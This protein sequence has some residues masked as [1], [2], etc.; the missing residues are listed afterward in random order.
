[1][2]DLRILILGPGC[3]NCDELE[4]NVRE[5]AADLGYLTHVEHVRDHETISA[6]G[7]VRTPALVVNG[8]ILITG[9]VPQASELCALL[10]GTPVR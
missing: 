9:W 7:V 10:S 2:S 3:I 8:H 6:Y 1:M 4:A 5:A